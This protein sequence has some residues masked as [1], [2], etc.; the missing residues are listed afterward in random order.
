M[1]EEW[2]IQ[3]GTNVKLWAIKK[4]KKKTPQNEQTKNKPK[5]INLIS[6]RAG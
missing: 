6:S 2:D 1:S 3:G 4:K 5:R